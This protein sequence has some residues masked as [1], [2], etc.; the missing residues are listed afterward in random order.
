MAPFSKL[1][2][3]YRELPCR[4]LVKTLKTDPENP[5]AN[6]N[7]GVLMLKQRSITGAIRYFSKA[8]RSDPSYHIALFNLGKAFFQKGLRE[9]DTN[10]KLK[11][12]KYAKKFT[13][14]GLNI[15]QKVSAVLMLAKIYLH[16]ED[17]NS[18]LEFCE[19][20]ALID[21]TY[22]EIYATKRIIYEQINDIGE[23]KAAYK[24]YKSLTDAEKLKV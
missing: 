21:N 20:A 7:L 3:L 12:L 23:A 6:N 8:V 18:A 19:K 22:K 13:Q 14:K 2:I 1:K 16:L 17:Y 9:K 4:R 24:N 5:V 15:E 10:E 11:S